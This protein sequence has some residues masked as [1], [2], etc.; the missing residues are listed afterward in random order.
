MMVKQVKIS[1]LPPAM[2]FRKTRNNVYT[3]ESEVREVTTHGGPWGPDRA[4][5]PGFFCSRHGGANSGRLN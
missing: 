3:E 1:P 2:R 4:F 5:L